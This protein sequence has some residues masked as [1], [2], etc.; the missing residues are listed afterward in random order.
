M[1]YLLGKLKGWLIGVFAILISISYIYLKGRSDGK[2]NA[3]VDAAEAL[4]NDVR[5]AKGIRDNV[6]SLT[7]TDLDKRLSKWTRK[8]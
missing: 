6:D 7:P 8:R 2:A 5:S 4:K 1:T 3:E